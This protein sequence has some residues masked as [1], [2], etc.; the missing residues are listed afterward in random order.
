MINAGENIDN[1]YFQTNLS[2]EDFEE[3]QELSPFITLIKSTKLSDKFQKVFERVNEYKESICDIPSAANF[4]SQRNSN[5][6]DATKE[7]DLIFDEEFG[8]E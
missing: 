8:D 2:K 4:R 1:A 6:E 5:N 3:F 7:L